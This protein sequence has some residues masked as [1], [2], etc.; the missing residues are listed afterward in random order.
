MFIREGVYGGKRFFSFIAFDLCIQ[1]FFVVIAFSYDKITR[2][3]K[4]KKKTKLKLEQRQ[5]YLLFLRVR[6]AIV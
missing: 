2:F 4:Q 5:S 1:L 6:I 3:E